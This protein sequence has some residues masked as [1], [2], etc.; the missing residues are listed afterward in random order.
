[1]RNIRKQHD[2]AEKVADDKRKLADDKTEKFGDDYHWKVFFQ[3]DS[4]SLLGK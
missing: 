1:L 2:V 4:G 3:G